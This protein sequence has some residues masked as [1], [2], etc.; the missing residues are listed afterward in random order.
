VSGTLSLNSVGPL[1]NN[2]L[3]PLASHNPDEL[4]IAITVTARYK[5][6]P[7][8]VLTG[9][10]ADGLSRDRFPGLTL[11]DSAEE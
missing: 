10:L 5:K 3:K 4:T 11:E 1:F 2:V 7:G 8:A 6:D 9:L